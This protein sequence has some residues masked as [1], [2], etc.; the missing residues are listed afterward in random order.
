MRKLSLLITADWVRTHSLVS[1]TRISGSLRPPRSTLGT[2]HRLSA[3]PGPDGGGEQCR[4]KVSSRDD[5]T[6]DARNAGR[7]TA[8]A[9]RLV[10]RSEER[11]QQ[12]GGL[13]PNQPCPAL[14]GCV[15]SR[16][17]VHASLGHRMVDYGDQAT[18]PLVVCAGRQERTQ[19]PTRPDERHISS[20]VRAAGWEAAAHPSASSL[21]LCVGNTR[22]RRVLF[23][24]GALR[25]GRAAAAQAGLPP[26]SAP[27]R[28]LR[29]HKG[30]RSGGSRLSGRW[31]AGK[32][33]CEEK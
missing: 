5:V 20:P 23:R 31:E 21:A 3:S 33:R 30:P 12:R 7:D 4:R 9:S 10:V 32:Q 19:Q 2:H 16:R 11:P 6:G 26:A 17:G 27:Q 29:G 24:S 18:P 25:S 1:P 15:V 28:V 13:W 14:P 8:P 22:R